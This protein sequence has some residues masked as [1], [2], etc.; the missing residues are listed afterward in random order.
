MR[1]DL[2]DLRL[3]L[4]IADA[5]SITHGAERSHLALAS[6]SAR[7]GGMETALGTSLLVRG[8]RGVTLSPAGECLADHARLI[9]AQVER[10][11]GDLGTFARGLAGSVRLQSNTSALS[12]HL[13]RVLAAFLRANPTINIEVEERESIAIA[14]AIASGVADVGIA[15]AAALPETLECFPFREDVLVLAVPGDDALVGRR[16]LHL[17]DVV[18]RAFVGLPRDSALQRHVAGHAARLGAKLAIRARVPSFEAACRMV[19][20]GAGI[21]VLPSVTATRYRR[22]MKI[23]VVRLKDRWARRRLAICV[24]RLSS[25]PRAAQHLVEH[26]R[27]AAA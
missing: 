27:K 18:D 4:N 23:G 22:S 7:I 13:P 6:A 19:E 16:P 5:Q 25:L 1:F 21:A 17:A 11:N 10:M 8:R 24:R 9:L 20:S 14:D 12:E 3:F 26:L 2:V 15:S